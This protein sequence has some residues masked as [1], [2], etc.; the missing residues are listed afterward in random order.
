V[1]IRV[2]DSVITEG[3]SVSVLGRVVGARL[4]ARVVLQEREAGTWSTLRER[5]LRDTRRFSFTTTPARGV[6]QLRVVKPRQLGQPRSVSEIVEVRVRWVP[7]VTATA[8]SSND[9]TGGQRLTV[10]G[11]VSDGPNQPVVALQHHDGTSWTTLAEQTLADGD[12]GY[13]FEETVPPGGNFRVRLAGTAMT[14]PQASATFEHSYSPYLADLNVDRRYLIRGGEGVEVIEFEVD[15]GDLVT[16]A[17]GRAPSLGAYSPAGALV[18]APVESP[19]DLMRFEATESGRHRVEVARVDHDYE[20]P[21]AVSIPKVVE[22]TVDAPAVTF[23][24]DVEGQPVDVRFDASGTR[25][26]TVPNDAST[27]ETVTLLD[28]AG[29][30][31]T[32]WL[33]AG[34]AQG[35]EPVYRPGDGTYRLRMVPDYRVIEREARPL[36]VHWV[37]A[38]VNG[39]IVEATVDVADRVV[40]VEYDRPLEPVTVGTQ[41]TSGDA[42][43]EVVTFDA[44]TGEPNPSG[45]GHSVT[46]VSAHSWQLST[47]DVQLSTPLHRQAVIGGDPLDVDLS[48]NIA[49]TVSLHFTGTAGQAVLFNQTAALGRFGA[50]KLAPG[51]GGAALANHRGQGLWVLP[52]DGEYVLDV[53]ATGFQDRKSTGTLALSAARTVGLTG[54][55]TPVT[56]TID[57][58]N[59]PIVGVVPMAAG[60]VVD[61]T[62]DNVSGDLSPERD[63]RNWEVRLTAPADAYWYNTWAIPGTLPAFE[64]REPGDIVAVI[65]AEQTGSLRLR[66]D[67]RE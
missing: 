61:A 50:V 65:T 46:A 28:E 1:V 37:P 67:A 60:K 47:V 66:F 42:S 26:F 58:P 23:S 41:T 64:V 56:V 15:A 45:V 57:E 36:S 27:G 6:Q 55:G 31:V 32:P 52:A 51:D 8:E 4:G 22:A 35:R 12:E 53:L 19:E 5:R 13:T 2:S 17:P 39:P 34:M 62:L 33:P 48:D 44:A 7:G 49:R 25:A 24:S 40:L 29:E 10:V 11:A 9:G 14:T 63:T 43:N 18:A 30:A 20:L 21:L 38:T 54:D 59:E 16:V 3:D